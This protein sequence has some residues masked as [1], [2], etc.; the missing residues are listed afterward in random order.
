[1]DYD[2]R[3]QFPNLYDDMTDTAMVMMRIIV[4]IVDWHSQI[5]DD[6]YQ[7]CL[8]SSFSRNIN[9]DDEPISSKVSKIIILPRIPA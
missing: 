8:V 5:Y 9:Y 3:Y 4:D 6:H 2:D 7:L 1:M